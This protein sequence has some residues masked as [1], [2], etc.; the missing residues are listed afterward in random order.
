MNNKIKNRLLNFT[1]TLLVLCFIY[2]ARAVY[3]SNVVM[4]ASVIP[5]S[6]WSTVYL[7]TLKN[8]MTLTVSKGA[9]RNIWGGVLT[10]GDNLIISRYVNVNPFSRS[11]IRVV[12]ET[13]RAQL[14]EKDYS[15]IIEILTQFPEEGYE[16][17]GFVLPFT[18]IS[19][20]YNNAFSSAS[21]AGLSPSQTLVKKY[22]EYVVF[23][24]LLAILYE[25]SPIPLDLS[26]PH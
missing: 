8:D 5:P 12:S 7:I 14:S 3:F 17:E 19:V 22:P 6:D 13:A 4:E 20:F 23:Y 10:G 11:I 18:R 2:A 9:S 16:S 15:K 25:L 21:Y 24:E 1:V 26:N